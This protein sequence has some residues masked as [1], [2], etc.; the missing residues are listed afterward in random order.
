MRS[1]DMSW[2]ERTDADPGRL[3]AGGA[4][5]ALV[6][7]GLALV[8][9]L[10]VNKVPHAFLLTPDGG[11][12]PVDDAKT[13]MPLLAAVSA[14]V[15]TGLLHLLMT[16]TPRAGQF[17]AWIGV[18]VLALLVLDVLVAG[19][20]KLAQFVT[21]AFYVLIGIMIISSLYGVSRSAVRYHRH[22]D[23]RD[24][25]ADREAAYPPRRGYPD[26][27]GQDQRPGAAE[28]LPDAYDGYADRSR[29]PAHR[30]NHRRYR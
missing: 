30:Q 17:F 10:L 7:A 9:V 12:E 18:L 11:R 23:Y 16:T 22:Q 28:T 29:P 26:E 2:D 19:E 4:V 1:T 5:T 20:D 8:G 6:A 14:L 24:S 13:M 25:Y 3:W 27:Y 15:A 21:S